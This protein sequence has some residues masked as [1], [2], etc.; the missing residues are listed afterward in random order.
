MT[1]KDQQENFT[2][3]IRKFAMAGLGRRSDESAALRVLVSTDLRVVAHIP[4]M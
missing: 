4:V 3:F 2:S 1:I